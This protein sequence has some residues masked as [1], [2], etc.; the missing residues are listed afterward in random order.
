MDRR[1]EEHL[2]K[3]STY[4]NMGA[5]EIAPKLVLYYIY[6]PIIILA[7]Y[8]Y[9]YINL[10]LSHD[11][12]IIWGWGGEALKVGEDSLTKRRPGWRQVLSSYTV[13]LCTV[14]KMICTQNVDNT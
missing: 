8:L 4:L 9:L 1:Y 3:Y 14:V 5:Q 12:T 11:P 2:H 10:H 13:Q 6:K 7:I